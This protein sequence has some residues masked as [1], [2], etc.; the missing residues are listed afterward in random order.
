LFFSSYVARARGTAKR[1]Q[2]CSDGRVLERD[3]LLALSLTI[4][5]RLWRILQDKKSL[6][7][8]W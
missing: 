6:D 3:I 5:F 2:R 4:A 7:E 8:E 1:A